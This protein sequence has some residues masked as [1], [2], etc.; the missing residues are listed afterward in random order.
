MPR[1]EPYFSLFDAYVGDYGAFATHESEPT[2]THDSQSKSESKVAAAHSPKAVGGPSAKENFG[3][4]QGKI[5]AAVLA[6]VDRIAKAQGGRALEGFMV[7]DSAST[8][9]ATNDRRNLLP[10]TIKTDKI[11]IDTG[12]GE[13]VVQEWVATYVQLFSTNIILFIEKCLVLKI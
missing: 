9:F 4:K 5:S 10:K 2:A 7:L 1:S 8:V 13:M 3:K 6:Q 12:N 11:A